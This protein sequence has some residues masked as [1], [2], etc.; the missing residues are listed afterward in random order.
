MALIKFDNPYLSQQ[1]LNEELKLPDINDFQFGPL[2]PLEPPEKST[3][4][5]IGEPQ[6]NHGAISEN[7]EDIWKLAL[8]EGPS[9]KGVRYYDWE[10]FNKA[11]H[12]APVSPYISERGDTVF[13]A[14]VQA[15]AT[16]SGSPGGTPVHTHIL[17]DSLFS[18]GL[19]RSSL[20]FT[21]DDKLKS[22]PPNLD[23]IRCS[24]CSLE[25][26][27]S[28]IERLSTCGTMM[29]RLRSYVERTYSINAFPSRVALA[30][31]ISTILSAIESQLS[32]ARPALCSLLQLQK[33]FE[34]PHQLL[35]EAYGLV[36]ALRQAKSNEELSST[37]YK[38]CQHYEQESPW[39]RDVM[40][41]ILSRVSRPWLEQVEEWIGLRQEQG[42]FFVPGNDSIL[43]A[44]I[45][46]A[47]EENGAPKTEDIVYQPNRMP[48]FISPEDG[49]MIFETGRSLRLLRKHH[50]E[51]ALS[52]LHGEKR[53]DAHISWRFTWD[54]LDSVVEKANSFHESVAAALQ[55]YRE[56]Q[57]EH[58]S[59]KTGAGAQHR[60]YETF[61]NGDWD[62]QIEDVARR[63]DEH[64]SDD[65]H[66]PDRLY[67]LVASGGDNLPEPDKASSNALSPPLSLAAALSFH[68]ILVAQARLVNAASIRSIFRSHDLRIHLNML[69]SFHLLGNG[70]FV[71]RLTSALFDPSLST[72]E[73]QRGVM[74]SHEAMGLRVGSRDAW[75]PASS[76]LRLALMGILNDCYQ[77]EHAKRRKVGSS[78]DATDLPGSLSF[79]VRQL[80]E[81]EAEMSM[82]PHS[83]YALDF[84]RLQS[85]PPS[86]IDAVITPLALEK[87][88]IIFKFLLRI[89]RLLYVV[90]HLPCL[91]KV[92]YAQ[93]LRL[94]V[95]HFI[96][97]CAAYFFDT[98]IRETWEMFNMYLDSVESHLVE[99]DKRGELGSKATEGI[100]TIKTRHELC[101]DQ[102]MFALLLRNRQQRL[103][104]LLEDI[105]SS[106]L[107]FARICGYGEPQAIQ[108]QELYKKFTEKLKIFLDVCRGLVG[109]K[110]YGTSARGSAIV[111]GKDARAEENTIDRLLLLLEMGGYYDGN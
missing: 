44:S 95:H 70:V 1:N 29:K 77:S 11:E 40:F 71:S 49:Q 12:T 27:Q 68:P 22:Y 6:E 45:R 36:K 21:Y 23:D 106:I 17:L 86:P 47:L 65:I 92:A 24:G 99:E 52:K 48:S 91:P 78:I 41:E 18:L 26:S 30:N 60:A 38:R 33:A 110:A 63:M 101:L 15:Q 13:D 82:D 5:S 66:E 35:V 84:L 9:N 10:T 51:H 19:G 109:K 76:E 83:L 96:T 2:E 73:R 87:Y 3:I 28:L 58:T 8:H 64:P 67:D 4:S 55:E 111:F 62:L 72:T 104:A 32:N 61:E 105:F 59:C 43:F 50:P 102:I 97:S 54:Q 39:L 42:T 103:M 98:G 37:M 57:L 81:T 85:M 46:V 94:Q 16:S 56:A 100:D 107:E 74:R 89:V 79:A 53:G 90:S 80:T 31:S 25:A 14:A 69:R 75:P 88:D 93:A 7:G 108:V 20:L 34:Q